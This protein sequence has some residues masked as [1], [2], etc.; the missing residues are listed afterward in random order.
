MLIE[1]SYYH[2]IEN[3]SIDITFHDQILMGNSLTK[4]QFSYHLVRNEESDGGEPHLCEEEEEEAE[5]EELEE[6]HVLAEGADAPREAHH[7]H[8]APHQHHQEGL[9]KEQGG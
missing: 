5:G 6:A 7:E 1:N 4:N 2:K 3:P 9:K 8:H